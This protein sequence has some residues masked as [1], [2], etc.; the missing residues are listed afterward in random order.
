MY[1]YIY[2][3]NPSASANGHSYLLNQNDPQMY[4]L[5]SYFHFAN[6]GVFQDITSS[7]MHRLITME[8]VKVSPGMKH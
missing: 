5:K 7:C 3:L 4:S 8:K 6:A 2:I 1:E